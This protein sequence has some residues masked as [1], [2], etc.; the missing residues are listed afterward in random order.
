VLTRELQQLVDSLDLEPC[1]RQ[2]CHA[3]LS[4]VSFP[5]G[6]GDER[7]ARREARVMARDLWDDGLDEPLLRAL[8][9]A[10]ERGVPAAEQALADVEAARSRS[11]VTVAVVLRLARELD[12]RT[13]LWFS[14]HLN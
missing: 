14:A 10:C 6:H 4:V 12:R 2:V 11:A 9:D 5:I 7:L 3:C 13:K 1:F 8:R